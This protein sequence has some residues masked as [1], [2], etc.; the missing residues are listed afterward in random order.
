M[1]TKRNILPS[2]FLIALKFIAKHSAGAVE[3]FVFAERNS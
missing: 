2:S 3:A 1:Q